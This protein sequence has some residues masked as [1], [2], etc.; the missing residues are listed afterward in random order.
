M[1]LV[2]PE[3]QVIEILEEVIDMNTGVWENEVTEKW[4]ACISSDVSN[5][6]YFGEYDTYEEAVSAY[7]KKYLEDIRDRV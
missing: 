3:N 7:N 6:L 1:L 4:V 2:I 5:T